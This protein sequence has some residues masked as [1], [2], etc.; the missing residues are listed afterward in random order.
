MDRESGVR[1]GGWRSS[2]NTFLRAPFPPQSTC[3][4]E[5]IFTLLHSAVNVKDEISTFFRVGPGVTRNG[6]PFGARQL[7]AHS[8]ARGDSAPPSFPRRRESSPS[9]PRLQ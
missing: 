5:I 1:M 9:A 3:I 4:K 8:R 6:I 7:T 2:T